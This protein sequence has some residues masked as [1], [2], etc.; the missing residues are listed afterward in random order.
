MARYAPLPSVSLDPRNEAQIVQDASQK[1]YEASG[2]TLN[3]F[4]AGNPLA[5][6]LEGQAFAQGEFLFWANQLPQSILLEWIGPFLGA[7]RRLGTPAIARLLVNVQELDEV[8]TIPEGTAFTTDPDKTGGESFTFITTEDQNIPAGEDSAYI[9]V[10]SQYV[11]AVYNSPANSITGASAVNTNINSVTNP[12]PAV[13]GS[14]VETYEEVQER[15]FTLIRRR[16]PVSQ[17]DWINFFTDFYGVGTQTS[18]QPNRPNKGTYNY[19]TDYLKPNGQVSFFVLGPDGVELTQTQLERG[20]NVINYSVPVENQ[21][22]LYPITLSQAQYN[23]TVEVDANGQFGGSLRN[24]S[25]N[26]RD[27]LFEILRPGNVFPSTT[28]PTP[29]DVDAAFYS[30][31]DDSIRFIDPKVTGSSVYNTPPLLDP[32]AA[33]YTNVYTF[34]PT[35]YLLSKN[36]LVEV[37]LPVKTYYPVQQDFTPYSTNKGDQTIYGNLK[38]QQIQFLEAGEYAQGQIAYWDAAVGGDNELHVFLENTTVGSQ[39]EVPGLISRGVISG[40]KTYTPWSV[41]TDYVA[42]V[43][44]LFDPY[45]VEYD[46]VT[47]DGQFIPDPD[48]VIPLNKRPGAF[49]WVVS[50][51][52]TLL[53]ST[54]DITGASTEFLLG[55]PFTPATLLQ[56]ST[57]NAGTWVLTPQVG[58]G[59]N[60]VAD[61][62]YNY[63]DIE[64]GVVN[65]YAYV[66]NTFTFDTNGQTISQSFDELV[67]SGTLQEIVVRNA[68]GGLPVYKYKPRFPIGTYLEYRADASAKAEYYIAA[69]YFTPNST[70]SQVLLNQGLIFPLY[71]TDK[72]YTDFLAEL[73]VEEISKPVRMFTFFKGD[74]TFFR[75]GTDVISYTATTNVQPLFEFYT[76][77]E[78]GIFVETERYTTPIYDTNYIPFFNPDYAIYAEDTVLSRD[79]RNLY[80]VMSAFTPAATVTNWTGT[81]VANTARIEEYQENLLRYV[82][83]YI[84]DEPILSQLGRDISAVKLGNAQITIVPKNT[85]RT[86]RSKARSVFVWENTS[87]ISETPQLS[88]YSGTTYP[89]NPPSYGSGTMSL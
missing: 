33:T 46:Y 9:T 76:Y 59:P 65:K 20:Q 19:L 48:S 40:A 23:L 44:S 34:D 37:T 77:L 58:S 63:V 56:G 53:P 67:S 32:S 6:L 84:C 74:R 5:A 35:D 43:S 41:G 81:T 3:D 10:S 14:D 2:E 62:Y 75:E 15:F 16:N 87:T 45:I 71:I 70:D 25:L 88:W 31:F 29:S 11:G 12:L 54:N 73:L 1:V 80:R 24:S 72:Q 85:G 38:L 83:E 79:E 13:G 60:P 27:R 18:V 47:G 8:I 39:E 89:Y 21:G 36:D 22:H 57:Y 66:I 52:F 64:Q 50:K 69:S 55:A 17:E 86:P 51:N 82:N 61:P 78:N 30:S 49:A 42:E 68:D 4:S 28:N 7:M 26:F